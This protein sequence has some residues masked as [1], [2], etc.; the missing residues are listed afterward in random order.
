M[1]KKLVRI[2]SITSLGLFALVIGPRQVP[3]GSS[4]TPD[5][6]CGDDCAWSMTI[7]INDRNGCT[8]WNV[9]NANICGQK[10]SDCSEQWW[11]VACEGG[12]VEA[13]ECDD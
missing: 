11:F 13:E 3:A 7:S 2:A 8:E 5:Y 4:C 12:S 9:S 1:V 10:F 6:W